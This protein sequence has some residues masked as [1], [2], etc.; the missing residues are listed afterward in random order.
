MRHIVAIMMGTFFVM[1]PAHA[2]GS[3]CEEQAA[4]KK[5]S[6]VAA[7]NFMNKCRLTIQSAATSC[8]GQ[9]TTKKLAGAARNNFLRKC[10]E[11]T[12][13]RVPANVYCET[14]ADEKKLAGASRKKALK[15]CLEERKSPT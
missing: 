13:V 10:Y 15:R 11:G 4:A 12:Q 3:S 9:A 2:A 7:D 14:V 5:L 6:G 1:Q 8:E